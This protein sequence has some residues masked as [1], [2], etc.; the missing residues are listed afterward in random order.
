[1]KMSVKCGACGARGRVEVKMG[2]DGIEVV[3]EPPWRARNAAESVTSGG[4][5]LPW[6][7]AV[8]L[9]SDACE[10]KYDEV[11]GLEPHEAA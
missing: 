1:V 3:C 4:M 6:P 5:R 8:F 2:K 11:V 7:S 10:A 9:C